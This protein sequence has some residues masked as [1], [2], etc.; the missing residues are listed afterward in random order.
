M[1]A[2]KAKF[3]KVRS[4]RLWASQIGTWCNG[5]TE[6]FGSSSIG[7]N[8]VVPTKLKQNGKSKRI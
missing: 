1:F 4:L 7:S 2:Y 8:P 5:S 3:S 6:D